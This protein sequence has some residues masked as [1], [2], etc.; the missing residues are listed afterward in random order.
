MILFQEMIARQTSLLSYS[1]EAVLNAFK[2]RD[3]TFKANW[4]LS[5]LIF[6]VGLRSA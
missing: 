1:Q 4:G 5:I 2:A 3:E 6:M